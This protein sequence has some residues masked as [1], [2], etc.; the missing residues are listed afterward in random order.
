M[1]QTFL[2]LSLF[3]TVG[4]YGQQFKP[5]QTQKDIDT[6]VIEGKKFNCQVTNSGNY[7][8]FRTSVKTGNLYKQYLGYKTEFI[9]DNQKVFTDNKG[10]YWTL[11]LNKNGYPKKFYLEKV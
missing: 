3:L 7:S 8:I 11:L 6:L 10:K 1:K 9:Y 2:L 5:V 4:L